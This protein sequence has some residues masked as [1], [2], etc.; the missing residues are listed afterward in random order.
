[1]P[2]VTCPDCSAEI[3]SSATA[4][5][6][7]GRPSD[8]GR[9]QTGHETSSAESHRGQAWLITLTGYGLALV[10]LLLI[11]AGEQSHAAGGVLL[12]IGVIT[13]IVGRIRKSITGAT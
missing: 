6:R 12:A 1:M 5:P 2:L 8:S 4:C 7:C 9:T 11:I 13:A 3:S 10:G